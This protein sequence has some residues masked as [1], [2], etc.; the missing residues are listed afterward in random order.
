MEARLNLEAID[1]DTGEVFEF[2]NGAPVMPGVWEQTGLRLPEGLT[3]DE[4]EGVGGTLQ[5]MERS[6]M[7]WIGD[8]LL[9]GEKQWGEMYAQAID[10]TDYS[11]QSL[12]I[13]KYVSSQFDMLRR[14]NN[15]SWSHHREAASLSR[16]EADLALDGAEENGWSKAQLRAEVSRFKNAALISAD[17]PNQNTCAISDLDILKGKDFG[18]IYADPPWLYG[19]QGTRAATGNHYG[20]MTNEEIA[21]LPIDEIAAE[22]AHL[23]LWTTNAFLFDAR[24]IMDAWGFEYKSCFVWVKPQM[25]IGNYWRVSHEFL[26]FGVRGS[27]PFADRAQKSWGEFDRGKHSAKPEQI[28]SIIE[29]ASPGPFLELFGRRVVNNWTVWGNQIERDLFLKGASNGVS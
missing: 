8:W 29:R 1:K 22:N 2:R 15:L 25:G 23:H 4:W 5:A 28:R 26:L 19:N 21:A 17:T 3:F 14:R 10:A 13:A 12:R 27:A 6:V 24:Q 7:W 11:Y 16:Q 18:T 9:Y 20:G